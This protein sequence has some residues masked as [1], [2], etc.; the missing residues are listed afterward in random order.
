[1]RGIKERNYPFKCGVCLQCGKDIMAKSSPFVK[2]N[3]KFCSYSCNTTYRN[4]NNNPTNSEDT[5]KKISM[6]KIGKT[7]IVSEKGK[8]TRRLN[9]L[10]EKSHFWKGGLTNKNR[11]L[12]NMAKTNDWRISVFERDNYT[13]QICG[14]RNGNGE[15]VKLSAHHIKGWATNPE[16]RWD[17][18]NGQ[19]LCWPCHR[20][21]DNFAYKLQTE[22][23]GFQAWSCYKLIK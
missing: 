13:C 20:T 16:C 14:S 4:I 8:E 3:R 17:I 23:G 10:G 11:L 21:T 1:M 6:S 12:R 9:N 2:P 7:V 5:R 18:D 22:Q 19:T 15:N